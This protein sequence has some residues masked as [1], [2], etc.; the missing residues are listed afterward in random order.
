MVLEHLGIRPAFEA[1]YDIS[2]AGYLPKPAIESYRALCD[3]HDVDPAGAAMID[4]IA[5]NLEP[6]ARLGMT[7]VWMKTGA[8]WSLESELDDHIHHVAGDIMA[9]V[10]GVSVAQRGAAMRR[11]PGG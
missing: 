8:E 11:A 3:I 10:E 9:W 7:T 2:A 4:D 5:R 6:A 1:I